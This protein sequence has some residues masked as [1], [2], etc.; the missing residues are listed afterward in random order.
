MPPIPAFY[1]QPA[2]IMDLV[3]HSIDRVLDLLGLPADD[4]RRWTGAWPEPLQS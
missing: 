3:D 1:H 4:A 2:S